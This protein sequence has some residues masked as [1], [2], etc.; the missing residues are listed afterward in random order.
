MVKKCRPYR[1]L[2]RLASTI[3]SKSFRKVTVFTTRRTVR[4][5]TRLPRDEK[6]PSAEGGDDLRGDITGRCA[7]YTVPLLT[8]GQVCLRHRKNTARP[9]LRL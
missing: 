8:A 2:P 4:H 9:L 5:L 6:Q 3:A 7:C 1:H